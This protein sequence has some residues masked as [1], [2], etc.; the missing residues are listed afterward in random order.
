MKRKMKKMVAAVSAALMCTVPMMNHI[1]A[2][3]DEAVQ[4]HTYRLYA[5]L[6]PASSLKT[7][8]LYTTHLRYG[9][10]R[11][12]IAMGD[13]PGDYHLTGS[14]NDKYLTNVDV[15]NATGDLV[16]G[17]TL[18]RWEAYT[19]I[20]DQPENILH[21]VGCDAINSSNQKISS[22]FIKVYTIKVGDINQ[23]G[24]VNWSD[25]SAINNHLSGKSVLTGNPLRSADTNN[26]GVVNYT[27]LS[28]LIDYVNGDL[29]HF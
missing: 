27:D 28:L 12:D 17:G 5:E 10:T 19:K 22:D 2:S 11:D 9:V 20:D 29:D 1:S 13:I 7:L 24:A 8:Y 3:A 23:D 14:A 21:Y 16:N 4:Y 6:E 26:D 15:F 25:V 18:F